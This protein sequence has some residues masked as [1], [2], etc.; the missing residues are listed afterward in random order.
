MWAFESDLFD[1]SGAYAS[2][3]Q[4]GSLIAQYSC[5]APP[6]A[7][8]GLTATA[9]NAQV[10]LTWNASSGAT[11][12]TVKRSTVN[13]SGYANIASPTTTSYTNTGLTN[14]TT[15]YFVVSAT[16]GSGTSGNSAQ[17]S[18][19]PTAGGGGNTH[20]GTWAAQGLLASAPSYN[21]LSQVATVATNSTY[22]A[23]IWIKGT[24][25]VLLNVKAG[26]WGADITSVRCNATGAWTQVTTPSFSTG[27][28]TQITVIVQ[29]QYSDDPAG[30]VYIDDAFLGVSGGANK[31][32]NAGF[33]SGAVTWGWGGV[34]SIVQPGGGASGNTHGG[35]WAGKGILPATPGYTN[36]YQVA[37]VATNS[38]YVASLWIKGTGSVILNIKNGN[39]GTD[40]T[41]VRCNG[42]GAWQQFT[43]PS[44]STGSNT[45]MTFIIQ[46]QYGDDPAGTVYL[47]DTFLGVSGST[48]KLGNAGFE[49][50]DVTWGHG[51]AFSIVQNP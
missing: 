21:N 45:Q 22:V 41:S 25:S 12:Y 36:M 13:G 38:T 34:F 19:T 32:T 46:D 7:P 10:A 33:E 8:T 4:Y 42:S 14:G 51:A 5:A 31:L 40:V 24:G 6:A 23:S 3:S 48:N 28:N 11:S 9:G 18:A 27:G 30:T 47:D 1:T 43:T 50:G 20:G 16:N 2:L 17:A 44:F 35:T 39:W 29:D 49:S 37:T 26:S 15:Y